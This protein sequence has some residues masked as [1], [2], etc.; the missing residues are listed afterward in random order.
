MS[1]KQGDQAN[2]NSSKYGLTFWTQLVVLSFLS[3]AALV[4][5]SDLLIPL[6]F[7]L[8]LFV[9]ITAIVDRAERLK[10][11]GWAIP[12]WL[13]QLAALL[14]VLFGLLSILSILSNQAE[15]VI[16]AFPRY[17][18]RIADIL[19][20]IV[21]L[22]GD[23]NY[24]AAQDALS[25]LKISDFVTG[26]LASARGF[27]SGLFLVI[28]YIAF[29]LAERAPMKR[30]LVLATPDEES[31]TKLKRI[32][33][34]ISVSL[35][36]YIGIKTMVS[37]ATGLASYLIMKP[38]GLDFAETWAVL[39]FALNF[40]PTIGSIIGVILPSVVALVQFDTFT[41]FLIIAFGCGA[42]QFVI[43]NILEPSLTGKSLNLSPLSVILALTF[44]AAVWGVAGA[45]MSVPITVCALILMSH[46]PATRSVAILISGDGRLMTE[47]QEA[48]DN[49]P[50]KTTSRTDTKAA[51]E[52]LD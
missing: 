15:Q 40:I 12:H 36:R 32:T 6:A 7:S 10:I 4:F 1:E 14:I 52:G 9:L 21:S 2:T 46:F 13:A 51:Q 33:D 27:L 24:A 20:R 49:E 17:E 42:V 35:Q 30:K 11:L 29:M 41:P 22:V 47:M 18:K 48:P 16:Q 5:A 45:L 38:V 19:S 26:A 43:G 28:L 37:L 8:F 50:G 23:Q 3:I 44:W 39:A 34:S 25:D 31:L